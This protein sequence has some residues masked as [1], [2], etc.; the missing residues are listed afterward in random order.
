MESQSFSNAVL[1]MPFSVQEIQASRCSVGGEG[2][3]A[4][5]PSADVLVT[6]VEAL[7]CS[8]GTSDVYAVTHLIYLCFRS[9]SGPV[10]SALWSLPQRWKHAP[11]SVP[12]GLHRQLLRGAA[13]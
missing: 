8:S 7:Y 1:R 3:Q 9:H 11:L 2:R 4:P 5:V 10:V 12:G 13:G 6:N